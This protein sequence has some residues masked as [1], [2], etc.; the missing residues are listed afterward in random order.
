[1]T[2]KMGW[3]FQF[4]YFLKSRGCAELM[5]INYSHLTSWDSFTVLLKT[6]QIKY[7]YQIQLGINILKTYIFTKNT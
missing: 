7:I 4:F 3:N 2:C 5:A 1:M 6:R